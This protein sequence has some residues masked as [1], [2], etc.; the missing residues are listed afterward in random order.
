[1]SGAFLGELGK[2]YDGPSNDGRSGVFSYEHTFTFNADDGDL[3]SSTATFTVT[4]TAV[5]DG[6]LCSDDAGSTA[7]DAPLVDAVTE[8]PATPASLI[9]AALA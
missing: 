2:I 4:V 6:P 8:T 3:T 1:M 7:E 5:N 9:A